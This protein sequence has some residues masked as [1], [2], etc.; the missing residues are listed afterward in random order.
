MATLPPDSEVSRPSR[1]P[2][3]SCSKAAISRL[4]RGE[5]DPLAAQEPTRQPGTR[6]EAL[7]RQDVDIAQLVVG[8]AE[9]RDLDQTLLRERPDAEVRTTEYW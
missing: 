7:G 2:L 9:V 3:S 4:E 8:G 5:L 1:V 6:C